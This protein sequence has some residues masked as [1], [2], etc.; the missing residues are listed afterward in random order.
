MK[1]WIIPGMACVLLLC[2]CVPAGDDPAGV[3]DTSGAETA[4]QPTETPVIIQ[5]EPDFPPVQ[6]V[7]IDQDWLEYTNYRLGFRMQVP[8][9]MF[10]HDAGCYW[11]ETEGDSSFRP[12]PGLMPVVVME[13]EDRVTITSRYLV[14]LTEPTQIPSGAGYVTRFG[15]CEWLE[16]SLEALAS[17]E[18]S[19]YRWVIAVRP[20]ASD[21]D[22]ERLIDDYYGDCYSL[23][24]E[25]LLE[26]QDLYRVRIAGDGLPVE[27]SQCPVNFAYTFLYSV[28]L[29]V[30]ATWSQG[31]SYH[32]PANE[33]YDPVYDEQMRESFRFLGP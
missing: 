20:A 15:G 33:Q 13:D 28:D 22:L 23:G 29:E 3:I 2:S 5:A 1:R 32:F 24:G 26:D 7:E 17:D 10:R 25:E 21:A 16:T 27:E 31:Q 6:L 30:A 4:V 18:M 11:N 19:S 9:L 14:H 8:R 12:Q